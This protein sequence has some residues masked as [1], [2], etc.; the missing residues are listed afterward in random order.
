MKGFNDG[1]ET[2]VV[3]RPSYTR[4]VRTRDARIALT[5]SPTPN[6]YVWGPRHFHVSSQ[7]NNSPSPLFSRSHLFPRCPRFSL[8][9]RNRTH[10]HISRRILGQHHPRSHRQ[11]A[12]SPS[13][14]SSLLVRHGNPPN[15]RPNRHS[16]PT[17]AAIT[18]YRVAYNVVHV[19]GRDPI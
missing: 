3:V 8:P 9:F 6:P 5:P 16:S 2:V 18:R 13:K 19:N 1:A 15:H 17:S 10:R 14:C 7:V 11:R 4:I 12:L